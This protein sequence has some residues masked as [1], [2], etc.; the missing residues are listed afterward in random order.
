M[1]QQVLLRHDEYEI[2]TKKVTYD[3]ERQMEGAELLKTSEFGREIA[4]R[5]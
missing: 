4:G 3:L 1:F 5:M 2:I